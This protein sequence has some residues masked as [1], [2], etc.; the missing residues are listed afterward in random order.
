MRHVF[1]EG[2]LAAFF[3]MKNIIFRILSYTDMYLRLYRYE[4]K[5]KAEEVGDDQQHKAD[6]CWRSMVNG[7]C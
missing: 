7:F 5:E 2:I 3:I 1:F 4:G 6:P